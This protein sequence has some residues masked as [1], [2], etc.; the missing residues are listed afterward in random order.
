MLSKWALSFGEKVLGK[1]FYQDL[2]LVIELAITDD[3]IDLRDQELLTLLFA[4]L[5]DLVFEG[6][7]IHL[8]LQFVANAIFGDQA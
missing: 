2:T 6:N 7:N 3:L 4:K 1:V 8:C 5:R